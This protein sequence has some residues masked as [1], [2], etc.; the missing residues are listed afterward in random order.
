[1]KPVV[2]EQ[3]VSWAV[4]FSLLALLSGCGGGGG[5]SSSAS[6]TNPAD[7]STSTP[8]VTSPVLPTV[9]STAPVDGAQNIAINSSVKASFSEAMSSSTITFT[10]KQGTTSIPG[11]ILYSDA[12][13]TVTFTPSASLAP[14]TTYTATVNGANLT[15]NTLASPYSWSFTT[16]SA[17][18]TTPPTVVSTTPTDGATGVPV[19]TTLSVTFSEP[20]LPFSFGTVDGVPGTVSWPTASTV[21]FTP[22]SNLK[23]GTTYTF[24]ISAY[25]M[26]GNAMAPYTWKFTTQ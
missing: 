23:S 6:A 5:G 20:M 15:G 17:L 1:M 21:I 8:P 22:G 13:A 10:L 26:A 11:N 12:D 24:T 14:N 7:T 2:K 19:T 3:I 25:D 4:I 9:I 18:D 16:A